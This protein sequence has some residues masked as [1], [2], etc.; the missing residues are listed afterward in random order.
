MQL[1]SS[2]LVCLSQCEPSLEFGITER[3]SIP[4]PQSL[5]KE[6]SQ[7]LPEISEIKAGKGGK[8]GPQNGHGLRD[9]N[10]SSAVSFLG[11]KR[12]S[13]LAGTWQPLRPT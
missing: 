2:K 3:H 6:I 12:S 11:L 1:P 7:T 8:V 5:Q 10:A 4:S 13:R 9:V